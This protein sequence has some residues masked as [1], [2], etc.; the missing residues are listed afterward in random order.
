MNY[1]KQSTTLHQITVR[2]RCYTIYMLRDYVYSP[3]VAYIISALQQFEV[4]EPSSFGSF[5]LLRF[6]VLTPDSF[7][8]KI[9]INKNIYYLYAEDYVEDLAQVEQAIVR[10]SNDDSIKLEFVPV[11]NP[12]VFEDFSPN[13]IP[14]R[15]KPPGDEYNFMLYAGRS[16]YD[17]IFLAKS[18]EDSNDA[19]FNNH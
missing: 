8:W 3:S 12:K 16:G 9:L 17:F 2:I 7:V 18:D 1:C 19:L 10:F 13:C 4:K 15:Y 5:A 11:G 14:Q 6:A